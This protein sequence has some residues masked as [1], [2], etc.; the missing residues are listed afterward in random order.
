VDIK[1][2]KL[3]CFI[4]QYTSLSAD[5]VEVLDKKG[6]KCPMAGESRRKEFE[7]Q[8]FYVPKPTNAVRLDAQKGPSSVGTAHHS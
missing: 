6:K 2:A 3:H 7:T 1:G 8:Y 4:A 5:G